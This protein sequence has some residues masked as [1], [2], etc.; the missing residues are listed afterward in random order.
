MDKQAENR[1]D[2][3]KGNAI[4]SMVCTLLIGVAFVVLLANWTVR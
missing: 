4:V 2:Q 1:T 3:D